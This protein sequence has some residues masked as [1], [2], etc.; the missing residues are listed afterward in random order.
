[1]VDELIEKV[2][3]AYFGV[4]MGEAMNA[5]THTRRATEARYFIWFFLRYYCRYPVVMLAEI[6]GFSRRQVHQGI[7]F[8]RD[9]S[10]MQRQFVVKSME[11]RKQLGYSEIRL[12]ENRRPYA[13]RG[14][15]RDRHK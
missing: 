11:L 10:R 5:N 9:A 1:M 2:V 7:A 8:I 15:V 6:Y 13:R 4:T 12:K 3:C 14:S